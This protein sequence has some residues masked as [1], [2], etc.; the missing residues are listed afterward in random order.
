MF[1][2]QFETFFLP[3]YLVVRIQIKKHNPWNPYYAVLGVFTAVARHEQFIRVATASP[4]LISAI[5]THTRGWQMNDRMHISC[6]RTPKIL[7]R[8]ISFCPETFLVCIIYICALFLFCM[9]SR[10]ALR[11]PDVRKFSS[12]NWN[13]NTEVTQQTKSVQCLGITCCY[14]VKKIWGEM[15]VLRPE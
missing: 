9:S 14:F 2:N 3:C 8:G 7:S 5:C 1:E 11:V 10:K 4:F 13:P 15:A 6:L 12:R